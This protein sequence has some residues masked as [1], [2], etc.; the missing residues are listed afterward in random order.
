M[1]ES[2]FLEA[3]GDPELALD[4]G[5]NNST[6]RGYE[7]LS[8]VRPRRISTSFVRAF[9]ISVSAAVFLI[10]H[11]HFW[12]GR[13]AVA[14]TA[15]RSLAGSSNNNQQGAG[16]NE[17]G[18]G[19]EGQ[20][21]LPSHICQGHPYG[22]GPPA[23]AAPP[24][25][26]YPMQ[27]RGGE[28][29]AATGLEAEQQP[30]KKK[31]KFKHLVGGEPEEKISK[32]VR[33][34]MTLHEGD[35]SGADFPPSDLPTFEEELQGIHYDAL[36]AASIPQS[37]SPLDVELDILED[38]DLPKELL[39]ADLGA[40]VLDSAT[41]SSSPVDTTEKGEE[42]FF[43]AKEQE[44]Q[45]PPA[46]IATSVVPPRQGPSQRQELH[47]QQ[48]VL[49][50]LTDVYPFE[51]AGFAGELPQLREEDILSVLGAPRTP[52]GSTSYQAGHEP[53]IADFNPDFLEALLKEENL[54]SNLGMASGDPFIPARSSEALGAADAQSG[55]QAW[56]AA[57]VV[58]DEGGPPPSSS[59]ASHFSQGFE[60]PGEGTSAGPSVGGTTSQAPLEDSTASREAVAT[61][62]E[63][64]WSTHAFY[65]L[66][67]AEPPE[68]DKGDSGMS[69][70]LWVMPRTSLARAAQPVHDLL[71]K[72]HLNAKESR[73][74]ISHS[75]LL[76]RFGSSLTR[77]MTSKQPSE[78][79]VL[80][81]RKYLMLDLLKSVELAL[82]PHL[83]K[84][85][86]WDELVRKLLVPPAHWERRPLSETRFGTRSELIEY[87]LR[88][89]D[90]FR[91]GERPS[92]RLTVF[93]KRKLFCYE[94]SPP[95]FK[96]AV[97]DPW[98]QD[99]QKWVASFE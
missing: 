72:E 25:V 90:R 56:S 37:P 36:T 41:S 10:A 79:C 80:L 49:Q 38:L 16:S 33:Q 7:A 92:P 82:G 28:Q 76:V 84:P 71:N 70:L 53:A 14:S 67:I 51:P 73:E 4:E 22:E 61:A 2:F 75:L 47:P 46:S 94:D 50:P 95:D 99:D 77:P 48:A 23:A 24:E 65:R 85:F 68:P 5:S 20:E 40:W 55:D 15:A 52:D 27:A 30:P 74:L 60:S 19:E 42:G 81:G 12:S 43:F 11:C 6:N 59:D 35:P 21:S 29:E 97:W 62:Q 3:Q 17:E 64:D 83:V 93:L 91:K 31:R 9:L 63:I 86:I 57:T 18:E 88:A 26:Y 45:P 13:G 66:P 32:V 78:L 34:A 54:L 96:K 87:L 8:A 39:E 58:I 44:G 89:L 1:K 69:P 98:R